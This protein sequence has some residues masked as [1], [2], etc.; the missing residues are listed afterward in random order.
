MQA[1]H[2]TT[3]CLVGIC[4]WWERDNG[5]HSTALLLMGMQWCPSPIILWRQPPYLRV[6]GYGDRERASHFVSRAF[7]VRHNVMQVTL[8]K[9]GVSLKTLC[10]ID[11]C[12]PP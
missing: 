8:T 9:G 10:C 5:S 11:G 12:R 2:E 3:L 1:G 7:S 6:S 4:E